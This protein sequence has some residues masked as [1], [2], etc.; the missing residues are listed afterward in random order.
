M[1]SVEQQ[2]AATA[3]ILDTGAVSSEQRQ[4]GVAQHVGQKLWIRGRDDCSGVRR[5]RT[6]LVRG[7]FMGVSCEQ[8]SIAL[9]IFF[10]SVFSFVGY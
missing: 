10:V 9:C 5:V 6:E 8:L 2:V 4:Q 7:G 1:A 3:A